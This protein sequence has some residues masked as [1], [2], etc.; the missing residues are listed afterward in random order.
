MPNYV[1][2]IMRVNK[3]Y[4]KIA[5]LFDKK[6]DFDFN[7][8]IPMPITMKVVSGSYNKLAIECLFSTMDNEEKAEICSWLINTNYSNYCELAYKD[9][10]LKKI[11]EDNE[12]FIKNYVDDEYKN[13]GIWNLRDFGEKLL[14][15]IKEYNADTWYDWSCDNWGTK[16]N[17]CDSTTNGVDE[18]QFETAW[19]MPMP[20][21]KKLS[22]MFDDTTFTIEYADEDLGYNCGIVKLKGGK[23]I[24]DTLGDYK[25]A[26]NL[27][28]YED[29]DFGGEDDLCF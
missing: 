29:E 8:I 7:K 13:I 23:V 10:D 1:K 3:N 6:E 27:W 25:F 24:Y 19:S 15:N 16:W 14:N 4:D 9:F 18:W 2:N 26:C 5:K 22:S 28:G 21:Y 20:I 17:S 11:K 12:H